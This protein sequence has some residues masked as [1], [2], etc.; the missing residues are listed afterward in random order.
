MGSCFK[1]PEI[2]SHINP[3]WEPVSRIEPGGQ[4]PSTASSDGLK[5]LCAV[6]GR[7][8]VQVVTALLVGVPCYH[9]HGWDL[10][11]TVQGWE[12]GNDRSRRLDEDCLQAGWLQAS[13]YKQGLVCAFQSETG[14]TIQPCLDTQGPE[15][16]NAP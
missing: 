5:E 3:I 16:I 13:H 6:S 8:W 2:G 12:L 4:K 10:M 14:R 1:S 15:C 7:V 9:R 11:I